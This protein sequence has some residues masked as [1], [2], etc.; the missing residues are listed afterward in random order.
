MNVNTATRAPPITTM[1]RTVQN[2]SCTDEA[3]SVG[4]IT[5]LPHVAPVS[6]QIAGTAPAR[7]VRGAVRARAGHRD[8]P[9]RLDRRGRGRTRPFVTIVTTIGSSCLSALDTSA[10]LGVR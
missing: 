1:S 4:T 9:D 2:A 7:A 6:P 5:I 10:T 8:R 3:T